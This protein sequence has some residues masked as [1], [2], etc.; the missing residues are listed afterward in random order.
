MSSRPPTRVALV[1][2]DGLSGAES[3][4]RFAE[5][6]CVKLNR[7]TRKGTE[8]EKAFEARVFTD[9]AAALKFLEVLNGGTRTLAFMSI[10][11]LAE[12]AKLQVAHKDINVVVL[13]GARHDRGEPLIVHKQW[14]DD[15]PLAT[16]LE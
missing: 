15:A 12:A 16:F 8:R 14:L 9:T 10:F 5:T 13:T 1:A 7:T 6:Q 4:L 11:Q 3:V 2:G